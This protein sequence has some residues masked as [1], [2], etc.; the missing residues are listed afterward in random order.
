MHKRHVIN[1]G[2]KLV[3]NIMGEKQKQAKKRKRQ[4]DR[5][6]RQIS[7]LYKLAIEGRKTI[8]QLTEELNT[9]QRAIEKS[10]EILEE[11]KTIERVQRIKTRTKSR[12]YRITENGAITLSNEKNVTY[13]QFWNLVYQ[14]YDKKTVNIKI[15]IR[16]FFDNYEKFVCGFDLDN[17][18]LQW[19]N[20]F[21][22]PYS[23]RKKESVENERRVLFEI[24]LAKNI[25][26]DILL[27]KINEKYKVNLFDEITTI[28][29]DNQYVRTKN[30][31]YSLSVL[32]LLTLVR[33]YNIGMD[34]LKELKEIIENNKNLLPLVYKIIPE[35][36][37]FAI[38]IVYLQEIYDQTTIP[39]TSIQNGGLGDIVYY[40]RIKN[41]ITIGKIQDYFRAGRKVFESLSHNTIENFKSSILKRIIILGHTIG[42][43]FPV[44]NNSPEE[45]LF[46]EKLSIDKISDK[47][48]ADSLTFEFFCLYLSHFVYR[49][50]S[51]DDDKKIQRW[52]DFCKKNP[53]IEEQFTDIINDVKDI[54]NK[55]IRKMN[56]ESILSL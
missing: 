13:E 22:D 50:E 20:T 43:S 35:L 16:E 10:I 27:K 54:Q 26:H 2:L 30:R 23:D 42:E 34:E 39:F 56:V 18:S 53:K 33:H 3:H 55:N 28:S 24:G 11:L 25:S 5:S 44:I 31:K 51:P 17:I 32:G 1:N 49:Y 9:N 47:T 8:F 48:L 45:K 40:F 12:A 46:R 15:P 6:D 29:I 14:I 38:A 37:N 4:S 21:D 19:I 36:P 52:R 7:I 41:D